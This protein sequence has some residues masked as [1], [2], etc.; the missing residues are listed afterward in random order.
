MIRINLLP[1]KKKSRRS[2]SVEG[3]KAVSVGF[4]IL[5]AA[6]AMVFLFV[7]SPMQDEVDAQNKLNRRQKAENKEIEKR[8]ANFDDLKAAFKA[9]KEQATAIESLNNARATPASFLFEL[10][11]ILRQGGE[12]TLT[13][14]MARRLEDNENLRWQEGWDPKHVW[15]N[16]LAEEGGAFTLKGSAQSDG[17]VTQL[18]HRLSAS[19][20]FEQVQPEGSVKKSSKGSGISIY[21]FTITGKV[22]Y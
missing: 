4:G 21:D 8:T 16:S 20:Y 1:H 2:V 10:A 22:R 6:G 12:P 19:V 15:I 5:I 7:H 3:E 9:A 11:T 18:A 13:P 17:D 14:A